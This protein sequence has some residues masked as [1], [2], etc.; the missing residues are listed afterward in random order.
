MFYSSFVEREK[1]IK[2]AIQ[3]LQDAGTNSYDPS[4]TS[5]AFRYLRHIGISETKAAFRRLDEAGSIDPNL[6]RKLPFLL[7][8]SD[9][10][11]SRS[12]DLV[13]SD[14]LLFDGLQIRHRF[15][16]PYSKLASTD[17][18]FSELTFAAPNDLPKVCEF[19]ITE[20][21]RRASDLQGGDGQFDLYIY[22]QAGQMI[23]HLLPNGIVGFGETEVKP[24]LD[25]HSLQWNDVTQQYD[26]HDAEAPAK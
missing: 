12:K 5:R 2:T 19:A 23:D 1:R 3:L 4:A 26:C 11:F 21:N 14:G 18:R 25:S 13:Y 9:G 6:S 8:S 17:L 24:F 16:I 7:S 20:F 15:S 22:F 10:T